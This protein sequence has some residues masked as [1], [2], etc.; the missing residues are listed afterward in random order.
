MTD[1]I[2]ELAK[3]D[4]KQIGEQELAALLDAATDRAAS[5]AEFNLGALRTEQFSRL[6]SQ[7]SSAQ[8]NA[9]LARPELRERIVD[10]VFRRMSEHYRGNVADALVRW[11]LG[12]GDED[13]LRY[14][15]QLSGETCTVSKETRQDARVTIMLPAAEFLKLAS[16]NASP[17]GLFM[18]GKLKVAGDLGFAVKISGL[19]EIPKA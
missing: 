19:F 18:S 16:G 12:A 7:S 3:V 5:G 15:C 9:V 17:F 1:P 11:R 4:P 13:D 6:L 2:T 8:I 14:E 10:E